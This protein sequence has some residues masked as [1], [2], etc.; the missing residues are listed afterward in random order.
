MIEVFPVREKSANFKMLIESQGKV[1]NFGSVSENYIR[2][3]SIPGRGMGPRDTLPPEGTWDQRYPTL[4]EQNGTR[5]TLPPMN[6]M[7]DTRL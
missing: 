5:D 1:R 4:H 7:T 3:E 6:R 2:Y